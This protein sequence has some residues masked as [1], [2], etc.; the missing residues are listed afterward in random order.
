MISTL[1][2]GFSLLLISGIAKTYISYMLF[3]EISN[4]PGENNH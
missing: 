1:I 3:N 4:H 2:A